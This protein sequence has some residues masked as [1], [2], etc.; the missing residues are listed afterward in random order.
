MFCDALSFVDHSLEIGVKRLLGSVVRGT[1]VKPRQIPDPFCGLVLR[2]AS[3]IEDNLGVGWFHPF[4]ASRPVPADDETGVNPDI[5]LKWRPGKEITDPCLHDL[6]FGTDYNEVLDASPPV[7]SPNVT[8]VNLDVNYYHLPLLQPTKKY[9]W[10]VDEIYDSNTYTGQ[11]WAFT[12]I[13]SKSWNPVPQNNSSNIEVATVL[14]FNSGKLLADPCSHD[15]YI[16]TNYNAVDNATPGDH[17]GVD[18]NNISATTYDPPGLWNMNGEYFWRV[19]E[20]YEAE[21]IKGY[22]WRFS[23]ADHISLDHF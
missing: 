4:M 5:T 22:I 11:I 15:V 8:Y 14:T 9:Y 20:V 19:D 17:P 16:G 6:F 2:I 7:Y 1:A 12:T 10:R 23:T 18:Y 21:T 3:F 13:S